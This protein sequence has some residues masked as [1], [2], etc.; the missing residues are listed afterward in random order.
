MKILQQTRGTRTVQSFVNHP[1]I[2]LQYRVLIL[3]DIISYYLSACL[4]Y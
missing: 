3:S 1:I 4:W 2:V